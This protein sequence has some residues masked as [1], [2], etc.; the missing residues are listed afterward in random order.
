MEKKAK[1]M[2]RYFLKKDMWKANRYMKRCPVS[3]IIREM[4]IKP[5]WDSTLCLLEWLSIKKQEVTDA[6]VDVS[7][8]GIVNW[9]SHYEK[10]HDTSS[11]S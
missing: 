4:Q 8:D 1:D 3:L 6:C 11:K 2:N 10:L 7:V 9:L 5:Q